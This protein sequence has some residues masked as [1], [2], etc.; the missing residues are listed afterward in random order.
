[1]PT[2]V[3]LH[4]TK[5]ITALPDYP[6][7]EK[8]AA[9]LWRDDNAFHGAAVMVG[10]GFSRGAATTGDSNSRLP[11]WSDLSGALAKDL[12]AD[13]RAD[14][15]RL[16]EE[17]CAYFGR[18]A[19]YDLIKKEMNDVAWSPGT[20]HKTLL[21]LPWSDVLTTNWDTLLERASNDVNK[22]VYNIVTRQEDL[23]SAC[24]PRIVKL[25]GTVNLTEELVFTQ[26]DYR[27][28][29]QKQAAFVN[30]AR[31]VFI[32]NELCLVGFSGDDPN[33]L[34][35]AGWVRDQLD[36]SARRIYL[37]GALKL[38]AAK[39]KYL[40]S[41]NV[42]PIDLGELV[43]EFDEDTKHT[44]ALEFFLSALK[45]LK[46]RRS[47]E[48]CP[49]DLHRS[50]LTTKELDSRSADPG[51]AAARLE[52]KLPAL[53]ADRMSYPG[54][55]VCPVELRWKLQNQISDPF[56]AAAY[57][58][59]MSRDSRAKMLYEIAWRQK[60]TYQ[61][62]PMWLAEELLT[63]CDPSKACILSI[64]QQLELALLL[65]KNERWS[66]DPRSILIADTAKE[67]L[68]AN[69]KHWP[70]SS[71]E[72][73][74]HMAILA[75][76]SLDYAG[77]GSLA[78]K[79]AEPDPVWKLR[80]GALLAELGRF[81]EGQDLITAAY[82]QLLGQ[83]RNDRNSIFVLSRLAW[84]HW[85]VRGVDALT[86]GNGLEPFPSIYNDQKCNPFD[87]IDHL[88]RRISEALDKQQK[89]NEIEPLFE[90][91]HYKDNSNAVTFSNE[92]HPLLLLDGIS[93]DVG[94]P[95]RWHHLSLLVEPAC[96]L[97]E[98]D[99]LD[100]TSRIALAVRAANSDDSSVLR[101]MFAR[102]KM[103][104]L[105]EFESDSLLNQC[106]SAVN[107]WATECTKGKGEARGFAIERLRVCLEVLARASVRATPEK[108]KELFRSAV[109][110]GKNPA[111]HHF[112]LFDAL[113]H[114]LKYALE[115]VPQ[116]QQQE[117]LTDSLSFP[118]QSELGLD[119]HDR[120][121][122]PVIRFP[123]ERMTSTKL[124]RRIGEIIDQTTTRSSKRGAAL[125]RLLPLHESEFLSGDEQ[126]DIAV[127][128]WGHQPD[129]REVPATGLF[130]NA[131]LALPSQDVAAVKETVSRYLF[132][133][134]DQTLFS[135]DRLAEIANAAQMQK[136][137]TRPDGSQAIN[138]FDRLVA[139][140]AKEDRDPFGFVEREQRERSQLIE[141]VL[142][143][144]VVP[145]LPISCFTEENFQKLQSFCNHA[146]SGECVEAFVYFAVAHEHFSKRVEAIVRRGLLRHNANQV[147][148]SSH[149]LLKWSELA[150]SP[151]TARLISRMIYLLGSATAAGLPALL[152]TANEMLKKGFLSSDD[153]SSLI[154]TVPIIFDSSDYGNVA[155]GS[156]KAISVSLLRSACAKL[157]GGL[158]R[159]SSDS[160]DSRDRDALTRILEE[161]RK[162]PLPEVRF[163]T[164]LSGAKTR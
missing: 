66:D 70:N 34:Q 121:P 107:Y 96:Q 103:A 73:A 129:Y 62:T 101:R 110:L 9:A 27:K 50:I 41:I 88:R 115:G 2:T 16:A 78:E 86:P 25:H 102:T 98:I 23:S 119:D 52:D 131:L 151:T 82:R 122:N 77:L 63:L 43:D 57:L 87:Q 55:L 46:P 56:P 108:S 5:T 26:E 59:A 91:G 138:Y 83:H 117:L 17:Y 154:E 157:A 75:R 94:I 155:P 33:F 3:A 61:A 35:W 136:S 71:N 20:L 32:E 161:A 79:I 81:Q 144:S 109:N 120:W 99:D 104:S 68:K 130:A 141:Q 156:K 163:A 64:K 143:W 139:W 4:E 51:H 84:A 76:D 145:A 53:E 80:K 67:I 128:L 14:P 150:A 135:R 13:S 140:R 45:S 42:V 7:L 147:A 97:V 54:W 148:S 85:L 24:S 111:L 89:R 8:L 69:V 39:R 19:L 65:L 153:V 49:S 1:M 12:G 90:P 164:R 146:N 125:M 118:L 162:D 58:S 106:L 113:G 160:N 100:N 112:W 48:W 74:Y 30:F 60:V 21:E 127:N 11:L 6:A 105:T 124:S 133:I 28:Y 132:D 142:A 134:P 72:V 44:R 152:W 159:A 116:D 37:V 114:L 149:A 47:W 18:P 22:P 95:L 123:G 10:A 158:L 93:N 29:R 40:D 15:L 31:Q 126:R 137:V 92:L 36:A 38:T